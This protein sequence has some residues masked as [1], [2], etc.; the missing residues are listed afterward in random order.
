MSDF[1]RLVVSVESDAGTAAPNNPFLIFDYLDDQ[2]TADPQD[3]V[4]TTVGNTSFGSPGTGRRVVLTVPEGTGLGQIFRDS[5]IVSLRRLGPV[6]AGWSY[7]A[8]LVDEGRD[9]LLRELPLGT[10]QP[11]AI[12]D[13]D[14]RIAV[15][16]SGNLVSD[17]SGTPDATGL[18]NYNLF[19]LNMQPMGLGGDEKSTLLRFQISDDYRNKYADFFS[20]P[21]E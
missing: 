3:D 19:I 15:D 10:V 4:I 11:D 12:G 18:A 14:V 6:A 16:A 8:Y 1:G 9:G 17:G 21:E 13:I 2:G 7:Y 5:L 20:P